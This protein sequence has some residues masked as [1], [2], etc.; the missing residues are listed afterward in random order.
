ML[1]RQEPMVGVILSAGKGS[2]MGQLPTRLPKSVLPILDE[3]VIYHQLRIMAELGIRKVFVL[4]G[5]FGFQVV[6]EIERLPNLGIEI[7]YVDQKETLGI[8]H[9][10]GCLESYVDG[11]FML[12]LGDIYF[13][14]PRIGEMIE[15]FHNTRSEALLGAIEEADEEAIRRNFCIISDQ[16]GHVTRVIEKP[17]HSKSRLKGVG[18][19]LFTPVIFDAIRRTP[20]TAM[21]DEYEITD[22]IQIM[23]D[24]GY[25]VRACTCIEA[26]CDDQFSYVSPGCSGGE[27]DRG[28]ER[29]CQRNGT[30]TRKPGH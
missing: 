9:C 6:R 15:I 23:I 5:Y 11:P 1:I 16:N 2:R 28:H 4:V 21:R 24:D 7:E 22:S 25:D 19:Y 12:F 30:S 29:L 13:Q 27:A 26:D 18:V 3:P 8:A 14:A 17:R 20:R 10:V